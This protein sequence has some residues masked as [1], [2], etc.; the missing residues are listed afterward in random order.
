MTNVHDIYLVGVLAKSFSK[1]IQVVFIYFL[2]AN[3]GLKKDCDILLLYINGD[4]GFSSWTL[5]S[6]GIIIV[7]V[8]YGT[9]SVK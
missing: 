1:C 4:Y 7:V 6:R 2:I 5:H 9:F 8:T 3:Q